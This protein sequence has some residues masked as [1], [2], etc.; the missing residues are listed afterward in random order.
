MSKLR[1]ALAA[2]PLMI[3][4]CGDGAGNGVV[5]ADPVANVA[6]PAGQ[7]WVDTVAVTPEGGY[8]MGNPDAPIKLVEFGSR[9]CHVCAA[10]D[11]EAIEPLKAKYI[12][13]G[14]LSYEYRDYLRNPLDIAA[15]L[16]GQ[17]NGVEPFFPLVHQ[18]MAGQEAILAKAQAMDQAAAARIGALPPARQ[19]TAYAEAVGLID[20]AKQRGVAEPKVRQC[21]AD[22]AKA[23]A[24]VAAN[25]KASEQYQISGT[26][27]FLINGRKA[28]V[29]SWAEL[30]PLIR[31][32]GG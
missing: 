10:F 4:G 9:T 7:A 32:A 23:D 12:A 25:A 11:A 29:I 28:D 27:T 14:K 1:Y 21:L 13:T 31:A 30:E 3:A 6:A 8:R 5:T 20:W 15:S 22:T 16:I 17:C 2:L 19:Y 24:L 26:P 18:M